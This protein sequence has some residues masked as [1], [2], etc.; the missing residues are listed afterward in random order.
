MITGATGFLGKYICKNLPKKNYIIIS[1][2][3]I[4]LPKN[5]KVIIEKDIF[6]KSINWWTAKLTNI[7]IV[8]HLAWEIDDKYYY[9][10]SNNFKCFNGTLNLAT[11]CCNQNIQKFIGIGTIFET[12]FLNPIKYKKDNKIMN[13]YSF[14][15]YL[16]FLTLRK[17][18]KNKI[19]NFTWIRIP[20]LYGDGEHKFKLKTYI[21][22]SFKNN[23][24]I[25]LKNP[26]KILNFIEVSKAA[27]IIIK[28]VFNKKL[29][30]NIILNLS[31]E[32][33]SVT[34]FKNK[35]IKKMILMKS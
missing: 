31:G 30:K 9:N 14:Y 27:K 8:I 35:I 19:K 25:I 33:I 34:N 16:T 3:K 28:N 26:N 18:F 20:Y 1:R 11:A 23:K 6:N 24:K 32:K 17:I 15:K 5:F 10:S 12:Y 7:K 21:E 13:L 22:E 29:K 4:N 2:K